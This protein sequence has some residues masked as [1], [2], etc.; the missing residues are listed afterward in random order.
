MVFL[1]KQISR[2]INMHCALRNDFSACL[3]Q[4]DILA[5]NCQI[6]RHFGP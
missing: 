2:I 5:A 6:P 1:K 4:S 3:W